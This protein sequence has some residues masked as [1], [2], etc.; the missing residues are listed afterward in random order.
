MGAGKRK[1]ED[2]PDLI[3]RIMKLKMMKANAALTS[4]PAGQYMVKKSMRPISSIVGG[5]GR[6][7]DDDPHDSDDGSDHDDDDDGNEGRRRRDRDDDDGSRRGRDYDRSR[8]R[9]RSRSR[10]RDN[11]SRRS[12]S[13]SRGSRY[14]TAV[15]KM[16]NL[17]PRNYFWTGNT[18]FLRYYIEK[19]RKLLDPSNYSAAQAVNF[20]LLCVPD[21]RQFII[22]DCTSLDEMLDKLSYYTS[23]KEMY[24]LRMINEIKSHDKALTYREDKTLMMY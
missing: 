14:I 5:P 24:L 21:D 9:K 12:R 22:N 8:K 13:R 3:D 7:R 11:G 16:P 18:A 20:M 1:Q 6:G 10:S 2:T 17:D 15:P 23:D 4:T 19:W